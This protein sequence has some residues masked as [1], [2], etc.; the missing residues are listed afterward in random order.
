MNLFV[1]PSKILYGEGSLNKAGE[2]A[3]LF[4]E[5]V[6]IVT[7]KNS[8]KKFGILD[9]LIKILEDAQ[10]K[11]V[12]FDKVESDPS[13]DTVEEGLVIARKENCDSIIAIGGGSPIDAAKAI[14]IM[15]TNKG[16]LASYQKQ[17][18]SVKCKPL[19]AIPTTAG[20]GSEVSKFLVITDTVNK[21]KMLIGGE[22]CVPEVAILDPLVTLTMPP[23]VTGTT[24]IDALTHA[25]E[26]FISTKAQ[27]L[28]NVFALKAINLISQNL[29][30][31]MKNGDNLEARSNMLLGQM[32]AGLAFSNAS[33]A[34]VHSMSRPLG[35]YFGIPHGMANAILLPKVME[36]NRSACPE[37]FAEV[38]KAM[39]EN[40]D[41]LTIREASMK[42]IQAIINLYDDTA[43]PKTLSVIGVTKDKIPVMAQDAFNSG[44]T[45]FNPCKP[46]LEDIIS[47]YEDIY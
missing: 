47:L 16:D 23:K 11:V 44:S 14:A 9:K 29:V 32:Y 30:K 33:V 45:S 42:A 17:K 39:G 34:L 1:S 35:A 25:I 40:I 2:E 15:L 46:K 8:C 7:G 24:G 26:A 31:A 5:K 21:I 20:T 12:V 13:I 37:K 27:P 41:N 38:A 4:G 3:A 36:F 19:I 18:P 28:T 22:N 10:L 6:M 43:L